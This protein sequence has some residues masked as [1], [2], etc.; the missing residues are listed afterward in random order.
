MPS[1]PQFAN[2]GTSPRGRGEGCSA[3]LSAKFQFVELFRSNDTERVWEVTKRT[4][5]STHCQR[6]PAAKF[7]FVELFLKKSA[8]I[9][10]STHYGCCGCLLGSATD[11]NDNPGC[12]RA[13]RKLVLRNQSTRSKALSCLFSAFSALSGALPIMP[14]RVSRLK[15]CI[16]A[17][18]GISGPSLPP[19]IL[20]KNSQAA[21]FL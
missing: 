9:Y 19:V 7:Q 18:I 16:M 3:N 14:I 20:E 17:H 21:S 1:P 11:Q 15:F 6:P 2:W 4:A 8:K 10:R 12:Q 5:P 13:P